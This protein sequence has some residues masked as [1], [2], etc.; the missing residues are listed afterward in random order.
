MP[1]QPLDWVV[2]I[3]FILLLPLG[4]V[5]VLLRRT[6]ISI[7][8]LL[9]AVIVYAFSLVPL[10]GNIA[11][12][13]SIFFIFLQASRLAGLT[14]VGIFIGT[15][16]ARLVTNRSKT[17]AWVLYLLGLLVPFS[18][19]ISILTFDAG[20]D[21]VRY[22]VHRKAFLCWLLFLSP[23]VATLLCY[24]ILGGAQKSA[25]GESTPESK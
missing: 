2:L 5:W 6:Q 18:V 15:R 16:M 22:R 23:T 9:T 21:Y 14:G 3:I 13:E 8:Q 7:L 1:Y 4:L 17:L 19:I 10:A 12:V 11:D 24:K 20:M 25:P